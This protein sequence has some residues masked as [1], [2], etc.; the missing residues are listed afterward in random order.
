[1]SEAEGLPPGPVSL[2]QEYPRFGRVSVDHLLNQAEEDIQRMIEDFQ[3]KYKQKRFSAIAITLRGSRSRRTK[4]GSVASFLGST[5]EVCSP[6]KM[7]QD[8]AKESDDGDQFQRGPFP[9]GDHSHG[10]AVVSGVSPELSACRR[11]YGRAWGAHR[12]RDHPALGRE[13]Q[14]PAGRSVSPA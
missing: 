13:I 5:F 2:W 11:T 7:I 4:N 12:P 10:C 8:A 6:A 1:M 14:S 9:A 3:A